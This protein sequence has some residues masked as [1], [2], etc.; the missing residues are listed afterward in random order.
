MYSSCLQFL[1]E[2]M[3]ALLHHLCLNQQPGHILSPSSLT[4]GIEAIR[5]EKGVLGSS[6]QEII[7]NTKCGSSPATPN[8][9]VKAGG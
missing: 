2:F 4:P 6:W 3:V 5:S 8:P 7:R 9:N 1:K